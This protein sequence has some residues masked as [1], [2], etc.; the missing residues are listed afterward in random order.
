[1]GAG[2]CLLREKVPFYFLAKFRGVVGNCPPTPLRFRRP[3][4]Y[5]K[6]PG[7]KEHECRKKKADTSKE[8]T[9]KNAKESK[10]GGKGKGKGKQ[11]KTGWGKGGRGR[12]SQ[13]QYYEVDGFRIRES[14]GS[15]AGAPKGK[16]K[17]GNKAGG[18][19]GLVGEMILEMPLRKVEE[20]WK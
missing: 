6:K 11:Q 3:C 17:G 16:G 8:T 12:G 9:D 4:N 2:S 18:K 7:H 15:A 1:M 14:Q 19:D 13:Q 5:C 10:K 20:V